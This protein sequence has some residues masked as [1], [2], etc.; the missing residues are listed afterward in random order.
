MLRAVHAI[1]HRRCS[2]TALVA[3]TARYLCRPCSLPPLLASQIRCKCCPRSS[4]STL[5]NANARFAL[6]AHARRRSLPPK[7]PP[8]FGPRPPPLAVQ[9]L[10]LAGMLPRCLCSLPMLFNTAA[11]CPRSPLMLAA[12]A[13]RC[14]RF[15]PPDLADRCQC[16]LSS[17]PT[18]LAADARC[19]C[20]LP[21][22][23]DLCPCC[24]HSLPTLI[25]AH[26]HPAKCSC[27]SPC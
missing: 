19:R 11:H 12:R 22:L 2:L 8:F 16:Y 18:L 1:A 4:P 6:H 7:L 3:H 17:F 26:H 10:M 23:A 24:I 27:P 5:L 15:L 9:L 14:P 25:S 13:A 20:I 21:I